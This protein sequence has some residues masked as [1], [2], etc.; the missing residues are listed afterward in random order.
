LQLGAEF[1]NEKGPES[2]QLAENITNHK[3]KDDRSYTIC[4]EKVP[5]MDSKSRKTETLTIRVTPEQR[6]HL[7]LAANKVGLS[8]H[9]FLRWVATLKARETM[10]G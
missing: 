1:Y 8:V 3:I 6:Y 7:E 2:G 4:G 9:E 10:S 5:K